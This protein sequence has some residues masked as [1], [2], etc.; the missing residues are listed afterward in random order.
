MTRSLLILPGRGS[1]TEKS[2]GSLP[3]DHPWVEAADRYRAT[4]DLPSLRELDSA[5]KFSAK[6]HLR[7]ANVSALIY[8]VSMLDAAEASSRSRVVA[9]A[10]NSMGW[11]TA[12]AAGG[13]LSF[14]DGLRLVQEM[15]L[16]QEQHPEG[17]Q[18]IYPIVDD[19][20]RADR[21]RY[22]AVLAALESSG[23]EA[24]PSI[25]LGGYAVLAG[26]ETGIRH[27]LDALPKVTV[28]GTPYP[29][30]LMQHGPYHTPLVEPV[31][32][33]ARERLAGLEFG[34]PTATLIDGDGRRHTPWSS[35]PTELREYTFGQ[36]VV[37]PYDL[38]TSILVGMREYAPDRVVLPGPGNTLGGVV[39]QCLIAES[40]RG[41]HSKADFQTLQSSE[42]PLVESMRR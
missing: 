22:E 34:T 12:L 11:Y 20:W 39:G 29:F 6:L 41:V 35:D 28:G 18:V 33:A 9:V 14:E 21:T 42:E 25:K 36:Q 7:P 16:L 40:W 4:L 2:L 13:A 32:R 19:E 37:A 5:E 15:A 31:S 17:G 3:A 30:R 23:G 27:L 1:Y 26:T 24:F 38:T 10:G 8:L